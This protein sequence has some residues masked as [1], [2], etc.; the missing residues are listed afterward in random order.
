[1]SYKYINYPIKENYKLNLV[2]KSKS[3]NIIQCHTYIVK[4]S[5]MLEDTFKEKYFAT[6]DKVV[7][8]AQISKYYDWGENPYTFVNQIR[9][10]YDLAN[11]C[12]VFDNDLEEKTKEYISTIGKIFNRGDEWINTVINEGLGLEVC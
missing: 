1:M 12:E 6:L 10:L 9:A 8:N 3:I 11:S 4:V 5:C 2:H 7:E